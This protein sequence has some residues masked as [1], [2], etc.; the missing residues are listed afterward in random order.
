MASRQK[1]DVLKLTIPSQ[2]GQTFPKAM[3]DAHLSDN[4]QWI[5][6]KT[7]VEGKAAVQ[8]VR[9]DGQGLQ[10]LYCTTVEKDLWDTFSFSPDTTYLTF[11]EAPSSG[12]SNNQNLMIL[13]LAT[14]KLHI[15]AEVPGPAPTIYEPIKWRDKTGLYVN[16][17]RIGVGMTRDRFQVYLLLDVT[18][19][20]T[21]QQI[22]LP[23]IPGGS[24]DACYDFDFSPDNTQLL[25]S[26]CHNK[27]R[28]YFGLSTIETLPLTGGNPQ[29][30]HTSQHAILYARFITNTT[31]W[32]V[33]GDSSDTG[34]NGLWKINTDGSG[35]TRLTTEIPDF[36]TLSYASRTHISSDNTLFAILPLRSMTVVNPPIL[37]GS[38]NGG[39]PDTI[40]PPD[41]STSLDLVGWTTF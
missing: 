37:I 22:S 20:S 40:H 5:V 19:I 6:F 16:S 4:G 24:G 8:L 21:F 38:L 28:G 18:Q 34:S 29:I 12:P 26:D 13:E 27:G 11:E 41:Q 1:T 3:L 9:A 7:A 25:A 2:N 15:A 30:I 14:G 36:E 35:L 39:N 23:T 31:I 17:S 10:T 32:F 33:R